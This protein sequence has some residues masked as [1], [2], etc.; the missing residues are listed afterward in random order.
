ML[1][2]KYLITMLQSRYRNIE[3][4]H[5]DKDD[6][7]DEQRRYSYALQ[8]FEEGNYVTTLRYGLSIMKYMY[9]KVSGKQAHVESLKSDWNRLSDVEKHNIY[10]SIKE[11]SFTAALSII[12]QMIAANADSDDEKLFFLAYLLRRLDT[13]LSSFRNY[14]E[15]YKMLKSPVPALDILGNLK[16]IISLSDLYEDYETGDYAGENKALSKLRRKLVIIKEFN[17]Q[18]E[19]L[20]NFQNSTFSKLHK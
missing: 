19:N 7:T 8:E 17:K 10:K 6:L 5:I 1:F 2:R 14:S 12:A 13:E 9:A 15:M 3:H 11:I 18:Y 16:D 4:V 20:Y